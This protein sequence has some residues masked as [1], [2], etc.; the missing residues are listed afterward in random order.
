[1]NEWNVAFYH[2]PDEHQKEKVFI[3]VDEPFADRIYNCLVVWKD[4]EE[5]SDSISQATE[6]ICQKELGGSLHQDLSITELK[7]SRG[8]PFIKFPV[9]PPNHLKLYQLV[10]FAL[11][12]KLIIRQGEV[13]QPVEIVDQFLDLRHVFHLANINPTVP[14]ISREVAGAPNLFFEML[15]SWNNL[16]HDFWQ[17]LDPILGYKPGTI[18][19][20]M[21]RVSLAVGSK[22]K[23]P[24]ILQLE[25]L[26]Q[27]AESM[28]KLRESY[29]ELQQLFEQHQSQI[30]N[31]NSASQFLVSHFSELRSLLHHPR[32]L[33]GLLQETDV[34]LLE[35]ALL[36]DRSLR[37]LACTSPIAVDLV[38]LGA[39]QVWIDFCLL[40][41]G[42]QR[43]E[44]DRLFDVHK[45]G[46]FCWDTTQRHQLYIYLKPSA[47]SCTIVGIGNPNPDV[48]ENDTLYLMAWG[49]LY[50]K[51]KPSIWECAEILKDAGAKYALVF[52]EGM[53]V[54]QFHIK[55]G[56]YLWDEDSQTFQ[57]SDDFSDFLE[58]EIS[59][60]SLEKWMPVP[61]AF[62]DNSPVTPK[63]L[64]RHGLRASLAFWQEGKVEISSSVT[65]S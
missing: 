50:G 60:N 11:Y 1:M 21:G 59:C 6:W 9:E 10:K 40:L 39:P 43:K 41:W 42:Y 30:D 3:P 33:F 53:D 8:E 49:H 54:F 13:V 32:H 56:F 35:Y 18:A 4:N 47:Y 15:K 57:I 31:L 14:S 65:V 17:Q 58:A 19:E 28:W 63:P 24:D 38:D 61:I 34:W 20:I 12:G 55:D 48:P 64:K 44:D 52:D 7:F 62:K 29:P 16:H 27:V 23:K 45:P 22:D 46:E 5:V 36:G 26:M 25:E 2:D 51:P 37:H